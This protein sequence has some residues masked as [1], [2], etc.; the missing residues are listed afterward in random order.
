ME[1]D[2]IKIDLILPLGISFFTFQQII[3]QVDTFNSKIKTPK[4]SEYFFFITFF[5]QIIAGPIVHH[6]EIFSQLKKK[7][8]LYENFLVGVSIFLLVYLKKL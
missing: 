4:L 7:V 2:K 1:R 3:F 8:K 5:P 6:K